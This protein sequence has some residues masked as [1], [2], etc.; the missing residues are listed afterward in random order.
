MSK[1][2]K[3]YTI[4]RGIWQLSPEDWLED[5]T[6]RMISQ[7]ESEEQS[8]I[9]SIEDNNM[10][11]LPRNPAELHK[12]LEEDLRLKEICL[13]NEDGEETT[14]ETDLTG[15]VFRIHRHRNRRKWLRAPWPGEKKQAYIREG[16]GYEVTKRILAELK[17]PAAIAAIMEGNIRVH[18]K[19][20]N[21][22]ICRY[23]EPLIF[24]MRKTT[25]NSRSGLGQT[26][27]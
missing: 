3:E 23:M 6:V 11:E 14:C 1:T 24:P 16:T 5:E 17:T 9:V 26:G 25:R 15:E 4:W 7:E 18:R 8:C 12:Q 13:K 19:L 10:E 27:L 2:G 20:Q 21:E 22:E